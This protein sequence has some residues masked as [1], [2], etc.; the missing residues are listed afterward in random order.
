MKVR[1]LP[2]DLEALIP[3]SHPTHEEAGPGECRQL[4]RVGRHQSPWTPAGRPPWARVGAAGVGVGAK[5]S[6][7]REDFVSLGLPVGTLV[8]SFQVGPLKWGL[9]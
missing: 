7:S 8:L 1:L 4:A 6:A 5:R 2:W 9:C 3:A